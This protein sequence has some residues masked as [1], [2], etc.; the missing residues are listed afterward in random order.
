[1]ANTRLASL[2]RDARPRFRPQF[3]SVVAQQIAVLFH[4]HNPHKTQRMDV[5]NL[6]MHRLH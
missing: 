1:M 4:H 6:E 3:I 2:S 5:D